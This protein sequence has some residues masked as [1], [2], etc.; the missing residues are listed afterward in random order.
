ME[1][2]KTVKIDVSCTMPK[3]IIR[4][5]QLDNGT[6]T[7]YATFFNAVTNTDIT[8]DGSETFEFRIRRADGT[9]VTAN[10]EYESPNIVVTLT[11]EMLGCA[12]RAQADI[13]AMKDDEILSGGSFAI[14]VESLANGSESKGLSGDVTNTRRLTQS[15]FEALETK[16]NN[17]VYYVVSTDGTVKQYLGDAEIASGKGSGA[18]A[19]TSNF[20]TAVPLRKGFAMVADDGATDLHSYDLQQLDYSDSSGTFSGDDDRYAVSVGYVPIPDGTYYIGCIA[21]FADS[22]YGEF[23][24]YLYDENQTYM[25]SETNNRGYL[26][27]GDNTTQRTVPQT[28]KYI[29]FIIKNQSRTSFALSDLTT[30]KANFA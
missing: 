25:Y 30:A 23:C 20:L 18:T 12:G 21:Q 7:I 2:S 19:K 4:E 26:S 5:K 17:T 29:R 13:R 22:S 10:A 24:A 8:F 6:R 3:Q 14:D 1:Y 28:A 15:E 9:L 11:S 27:W 16:S